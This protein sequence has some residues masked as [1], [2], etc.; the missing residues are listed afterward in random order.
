MHMPGAAKGF[1]CLKN[2]EGLIRSLILQV[3]GRAHAGD[4]SAHDEDVEVLNTL[5]ALCCRVCGHGHICPLISTSDTKTV[6][7]F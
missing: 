1:V 7:P 4:A 6:A 2:H 3:V 5:L